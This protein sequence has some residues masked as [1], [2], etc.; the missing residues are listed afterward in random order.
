MAGKKAKVAFDLCLKWLNISP[1][2]V[3]KGN[4][5]SEFEYGI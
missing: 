3:G 1:I 5:K 4:R 2:P